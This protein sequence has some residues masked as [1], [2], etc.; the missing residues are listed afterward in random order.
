[1]Q[2]RR[3]LPEGERAES[4]RVTWVFPHDTPVGT[5]VSYSD[6]RC[7]K[8]SAGGHGGHISYRCSGPDHVQAA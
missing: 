7:S 6:R 1:V 4:W 5:V 3:P 2:C 8:R